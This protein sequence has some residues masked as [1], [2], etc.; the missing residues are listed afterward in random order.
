MIYVINLNGPKDQVLAS[1]LAIHY[2]AVL[3][4]EFDCTSEW[5]CLL[6]FINEISDYLDQT[7]QEFD[8]Y[9]VGLHLL[10]SLLV[11]AAFLSSDSEQ[12]QGTRAAGPNSLSAF[13][14]PPLLRL[15]PR[16]RLPHPDGPA[17]QASATIQSPR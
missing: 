2:S 10:L 11:P 8:H 13:Q 4:G 14:L 6:G 16:P 15:V 9:V 1:N 5:P 12:G 17:V 3:R 7:I